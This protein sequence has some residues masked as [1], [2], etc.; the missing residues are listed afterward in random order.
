MNCNCVH[1]IDFIDIIH[2]TTLLHELALRV[3]Y[4]FIT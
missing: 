4:I 1:L 2:G 3:L